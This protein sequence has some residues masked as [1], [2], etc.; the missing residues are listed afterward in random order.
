MDP[1]GTPIHEQVFGDKPCF[2]LTDPLPMPKNTLHGLKRLGAQQLALGPR[3]PIASPYVM[4]LHQPLAD[5]VN[6]EL[7]AGLYRVAH[8]ANPDLILDLHPSLHLRYILFIYSPTFSLF[9]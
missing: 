5:L 6:R 1:K 9:L 8:P 4:L 2:L 7:Q 3:L